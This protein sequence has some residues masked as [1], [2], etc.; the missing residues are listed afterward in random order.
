[1]DRLLQIIEN[2]IA[3]IGLFFL[4]TFGYWF[5]SRDSIIDD[6]KK[7]HKTKTINKKL[8]SEKSLVRRMF[9]LNYKNTVPKKR[10][11]IFIIEFVLYS[12]SMLMF[13]IG[14][15]FAPLFCNL[16]LCSFI[17]SILCQLC[18]I[19]RYRNR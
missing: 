4:R 18:L 14:W 10:F 19:W 9:L 13:F 12:T 11:Y 16:G 3:V 6:I 2:L 8:H 17:T 7:Q 1:M 5:L 15:S